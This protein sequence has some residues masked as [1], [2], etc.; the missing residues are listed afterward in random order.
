MFDS[1][2]YVDLIA[3]YLEA[4]GFGTGARARRRALQILNDLRGGQEGEVDV[5]TLL[6]AAREHAA[7]AASLNERPLPPEE[8]VRM[9]PQSF[10]YGGRSKAR[11]LMSPA[12]RGEREGGPVTVVR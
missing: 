4:L 9:P 6:R 7:L 1:N 10:R 8:P 11:D 2:G 5:S 3:R 12:G